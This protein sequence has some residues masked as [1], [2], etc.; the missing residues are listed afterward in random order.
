MEIV[1]TATLTPTPID[2]YAFRAGR[3]P[4]KHPTLAVTMDM[5]GTA[6]TTGNTGTRMGS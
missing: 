1:S 5:A 2:I 6:T 3:G 4:L